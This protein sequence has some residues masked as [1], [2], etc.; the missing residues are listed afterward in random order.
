M[1]VSPEN[2]R[3]MS[4][5]TGIK[6][7]QYARSIMKQ[8]LA[9]DN[10]ADMAGS[11]EERVHVGVEAMLL[12]LAMEFALK[13]W[14]ALDHERV[15]P[16]KTHNLTTLYDALQTKSKERLNTE[17]KKEVAPSISFGRWMDYS[18]RDVLD[19]HANSFVE[20]RYFYEKRDRPIGFNY[21]AFTATLQLVLDE[22]GKNYTTEEIKPSW[23]LGAQFPK[24]P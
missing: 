5:S 17:F 13:A 20:W 15:D 6:L 11:A 19:Y 14:F 1:P 21:T 18:I 3:V 22:F 16:I 8:A 10:G 4:F 2:R 23:I 24:R 9:M 12:A 7:E